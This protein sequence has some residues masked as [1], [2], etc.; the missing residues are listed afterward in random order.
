MLAACG[1]AWLQRKCNGLRLGQRIPLSSILLAVALFAVVVD[2]APSAGAYQS[3]RAYF[4][5][6]E[7]QAYAWLKEHAPEAQQARLWEV[8]V[9]P[10]DQYLRTYSLSQAPL[11]RF[12]GYYDNGAPLHAWQQGAWTDLRTRLRL[13]NVQY[14]MVRDADPDMDEL[15][16][17]L[18]SFGYRVVFGVEGVEIWENRE[19]GDYARFH[20]LVA[21][22]A[23][24][25]LHTPFRALPEFVWRDIAMV[26]LP[27]YYLDERAAEKIEDYDYILV[28]DPAAG[29][30]P[31][32]QDLSPEAHSRM[33]TPDQVEWLA[34]EAAP[35]AGVGQGSIVLDHW[36]NGRL[37]L[38][39]R[40]AEKGVL[41]ISESWYP[42]WRVWVDGQPQPLLRA[43]WASLG[44][45][46]EPGE[47]QVEFRF[48]RPWYA[49]LG[50]IISA[51]TWMAVAAW[52]AHSAV[53]RFKRSSRPVI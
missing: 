37:R 41:V 7:Q 9:M 28:D 42:H 14:V 34:R 25:D 29:E 33:L 22:D 11:M 2:F 4:S 39:V 47:H 17:Q 52:L 21:L 8:S 50:S 16:E 20:G 31:G 3:T 40:A 36:R 45:W 49:Y 38:L 30:S 46:L 19:I 53:D 26:T 23:S 6:E 35:A 5:P 43:D 32:L 18:R 1:W 27:S 44:V 10:R 12:S 15:R 51:L 48:Q 24:R 13:Q